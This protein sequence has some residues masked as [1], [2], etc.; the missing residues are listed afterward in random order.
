[1]KIKRYVDQSSRW[2]KSLKCLIKVVKQTNEWYF[3][4]EKPSAE[5][6]DNYPLSVCN[7]LKRR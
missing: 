1:M 2:L 6:T 4:K 3:F 5:T 7:K